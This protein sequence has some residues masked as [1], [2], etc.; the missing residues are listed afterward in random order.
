M[1]QLY[2]SNRDDNMLFLHASLGYCSSIHNSCIMKLSDI[3][4]KMNKRIAFCTSRGISELLDK[5]FPKLR[6]DEILKCI[7]DIYL[8][9]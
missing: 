9:C 6:L 4:Q 5:V 8:V 1:C 7:V 3:Y 2:G